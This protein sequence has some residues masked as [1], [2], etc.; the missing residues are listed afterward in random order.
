MKKKNIICQKKMASDDSEASDASDDSHGP[1]EFKAPIRPPE[2]PS[3]KAF[4]SANLTRKKISEAIQ[5]AQIKELT[6]DLLFVI[7]SYF[8][9]I[10]ASFFPLDIPGD[11]SDICWYH[12]PSAQEEEDIRIFASYRDEIYVINL[13]T[14]QR[15]RLFCQFNNAY[16]GQHLLLVSDYHKRQNEQFS[17]EPRPLVVHDGVHV[18]NFYDVKSG[19][20]QL[21]II[22]DPCQPYSYNPSGSGHLMCFSWG[23]NMDVTF[24]YSL[25]PYGN[26]RQQKILNRVLWYIMCIDC[27]SDI[28]FIDGKKWKQFEI[29][30]P[31]IYIQRHNHIYPFKSDRIYWHHLLGSLPGNFL[32][33]LK[34]YPP[35]F[36]IISALE[37]LQNRNGDTTHLFIAIYA[38]PTEYLLL[39]DFKSKGSTCLFSRHTAG[40]LN[41]YGISKML[42]HSPSETLFFVSIGKIYKLYVPDYVLSHLSV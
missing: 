32:C 28:Y 8:P 12:S 41:H 14:E 25:S 24:L 1:N 3:R 35:D 39:F 29:Q 33:F 7:C 38:E 34:A 10:E 18:V 2:P 36:R 4:R 6:R 15:E 16:D 30:R 21:P 13:S 20:Q 23:T 22:R 9:Q 31:C 40:F 37:I 42:W 17:N 5:K 19:E 27:N 11:I 26:Y